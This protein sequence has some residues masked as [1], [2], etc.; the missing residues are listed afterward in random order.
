MHKGRAM[1][2]AGMALVLAMDRVGDM[3]PPRA[4]GCHFAGPA[5][6]GATAFACLA[7]TE[8]TAQWT[9]ESQ[10]PAKRACAESTTSC[11]HVMRLGHLI[12]YYAEDDYKRLVQDLRV[13]VT[14]GL[15]Y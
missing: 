1:A 7:A 13:N 14:G 5:A 12:D 2:M 11:L 8:A 9:K 15:V 4:M 3:P 6:T 10:V